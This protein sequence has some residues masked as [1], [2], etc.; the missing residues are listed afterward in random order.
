MVALRKAGLSFDQS[1][2]ALLLPRPTKPL[3]AW[4]VGTDKSIREQIKERYMGP[5][6]A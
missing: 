4:T 6:V 1:I 3:A 5:A 2:S